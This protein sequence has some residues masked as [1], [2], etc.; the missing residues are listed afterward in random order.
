VPDSAKASEIVQFGVFEVDRRVGELR[1]RGLKIRLQD[2][3]LQILLMLLERPGAVVSREEIQA[4]LWP[5]GTVVEFEHSIGTAIKKLRQALG[6]D[7]DTP[8]YIE[9]LPRRGFRFIAPISSPPPEVAIAPPLQ[10]LPKP[11]PSEGKARGTGA[12]AKWRYGLAF[13]ALL[14]AGFVALFIA[15]RREPPRTGRLTN[16]KRLTFDAGLQFGPTWSPDGRFLAYSSDREGKFNIWVQQEGGIHPV[17]ITSGPGNNWQPDWSPDGRRIVFRSEA[18]GGLFVIPAL[19]GPEQ[20]I[21]SFGYLP[22]WSPDG[23][24]VLF[25][26]TF[27]SYVSKI[28]VVGIDGEAPRE[29]LTDF[30]KKSQIQ[31]RAVGWYPRGNR[32]SIWGRGIHGQ[33]LW[34]VSLDG[35]GAVESAIGKE[36]IAQWTTFG[37]ERTAQFQWEPSGR[38]IY[39]QGD[40]RGVRNIW[41]I[42][43]DAS[44]LRF[45]SIERLTTGPG[46]DTD[47]AISRDGKKL[48]YASCNASTRVW[49]FPFHANAGRLEG[50][51]RAVSPTGFDAWRADISRDGKYVAY[52]ANHGGEFELWQTSLPGGATTSLLRTKDSPANPRWSPDSQWIGVSHGGLALLPQ[53]GGSAVRVTSSSF[54]GDVADWS[55]D[56]KWVLAEQAIHDPPNPME[57][58]AVLLPLSAAPKAET[59]MRIVTS[60]RSQGVYTGIYEIRLSPDGRWVVFEAV[61]GGTAPGG[62]TNAF[63]CFAPSSGGPWT[64][65]TDGQFWD[66]KPRWSPDG[67][68]HFFCLVAHRISQ[69]V[70]SSLRYRVGTDAGATLPSER[71]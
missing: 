39:F 46:P 60:G 54:D 61:Q 69:R 22:R 27:V 59:G 65:I 49:S 29:V 48:A 55:P 4:R 51:G 13:G 21:S 10:S 9:T 43:V 62:A 6:D 67:K 15:L 57:L 17:K 41:K 68:N 12:K 28:Y 14:L 38:A 32:I 50:E 20:K 53:G 45:L 58:R 18:G 35:T 1:K 11:S 42:A 63:L 23:S 24:Q 47:L 31:A 64:R 33:G 52:Q 25:G 37:K 2:Q 3:P 71:V 5:S 56:G 70:G 26:N 30:L 66:D 19:G 8:H 36:M 16:L 40:S 7:A 44:T 34:T